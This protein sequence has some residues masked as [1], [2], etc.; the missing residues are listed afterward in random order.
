MGYGDLILF[1][2]FLIVLSLFF[3]AIRNTYDDPLLRKYHRQGFWIKV[4]GCI[5]FFTYSV[6]LSPGDS[7]GLYQKEG[8]N[9][10]HLILHDSSHLNWLFQKGKFF[11]ES[12]LKD[13]YNAGY[14]KGE[15]NFMVTRIVAIL[16]FITAGRYAVISLLFA[17]IAFSGIWKLFLFFYEQYPHMHKKFAIAILFFPTFVFWSGG[18]LKDSLCIASLGWITYS[19]YEI[20]YRKKNFLKN[21]II[22]F[23]FGYLLAIL[24]VYILISYVPFFIFFV[25][26]KN[27][28]GIKNKLLKYL[29]AP[30]LILA[31]ML[32]FT[33]AL[34]SFDEELGAYA[35]KDLTKSIQHLNSGFKAMNGNE[36]AESNFDLGIQFDGSFTGLIKLAPVA[37]ATTFFRPF[38]WESHKASQLLA[39]LESFVLMFFTL[40]IIF[41]SGLRTLIKLILTDPLIMYCFFFSIVFA[42][43]VGASTL[44]FGTLVRYKIP[45]LPFYAISLF[46][47]YEKVKERSIRRTL[48]KAGAVPENVISFVPAIS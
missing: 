40:F 16:S 34:S 22:L 47:I 46:L 6:Y 44:N 45:C 42:L 10:Y 4:I 31:C 29:L 33:Q 43:F 26:L 39:S 7:I 25:I 23:I 18:V 30:A 20:L 19:I 3:R 38:I 41:K 2:V 17:C 12:F 35:V 24:K 15:A 13:P 9:I 5:A 27:M 37:I 14:F 28:Q 1:P 48:Q 21:S 8:N 11:D 32:G 36:T